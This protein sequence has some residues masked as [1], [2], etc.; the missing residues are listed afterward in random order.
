MLQQATAQGNPGAV[1]MVVVGLHVRLHEHT[2][3]V[4]PARGVCLL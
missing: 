2:G 4:Q 3:M 1:A